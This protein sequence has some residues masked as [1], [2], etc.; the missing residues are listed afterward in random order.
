MPALTTVAGIPAITLT[1]PWPHMITHHGK[2]IEN[3]KWRP[4]NPPP[5][6]LIHAGK[7]RA[8]EWALDLRAA[9]GDCPHASAFPTSVVV[10]VVD[11]GDICDARPHR[12]DC[13]PWASNQQLHW[14][15]TNP[16]VL[17][18]PVSC[19]GRQGLW[20]PRP[21][22]VAAIDAQLAAL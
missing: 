21:E 16:R 8:Y 14:R 15:L 12:C 9:F 1:N 22:V 2:N 4:T 20:Y 5:A 3:R 10:A 18:V 17:P 7:A 19:P 13:G 6:L 11:L